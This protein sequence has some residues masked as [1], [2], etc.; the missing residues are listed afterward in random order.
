MP[1]QIPSWSRVDR[2]LDVRKLHVDPHDLWI[3]AGHR[4]DSNTIVLLLIDKLDAKRH[5]GAGITVVRRIVQQYWPHANKFAGRPKMPLNLTS[6]PSEHLV[7]GVV[8]H[9]TLGVP[10]VDHLI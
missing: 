7:N 3:G 6:R 8:D 1:F 5:V 4:L 2:H 9:Q 10:R